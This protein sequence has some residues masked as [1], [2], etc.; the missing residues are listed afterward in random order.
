MPDLIRHPEIPGAGK[1]KRA[2]WIPAFAGMTNDGR[3]LYVLD[4]S[5]TDSKSLP[6]I[7]YGA[8]I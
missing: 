7:K 2:V 4:N 3:E 6:D 8:G 5:L 1:W